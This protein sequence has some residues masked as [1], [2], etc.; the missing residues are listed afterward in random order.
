MQINSQQSYAAT[1]DQ[2]FAM[3]TDEAYLAACCDRFGAKERTIEVNGSTTTVKMKLPAPAQVQKFVG[4][5]MPLNQ[6][7]TWGE[8]TVDGTRSGTLQMSIDKMPVKVAGTAV[9]RPGGEGTEVVYTTELDVKI[10]LVGKKLEAEAA[11]VAQRALDA[12]QQVGRD[13]LANKA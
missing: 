13:Y 12:Q 7:I 6:V 11:P 8:A 1:P 5:T 4:A 2:V 10:P 3:M 9:M